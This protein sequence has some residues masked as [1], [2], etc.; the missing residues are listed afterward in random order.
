[1]AAF[2]VPIAKYNTQLTVTQVKASKARI[3]YC[4]AIWYNTTTSNKYTAYA[5]ENYLQDTV[6]HG[7][8]MMLLKKAIF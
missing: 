7:S 5:I 6:T 3:T 4:L 8:V 1:M 2:T